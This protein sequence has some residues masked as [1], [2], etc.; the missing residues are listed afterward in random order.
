MLKRQ[1]LAV[2][3]I[4]LAAHVRWQVASERP[5]AASS[6]LSDASVAL[7]PRA[8]LLRQR[9][10]ADNF[11]ATALAETSERQ[12]ST[13]QEDLE[14]KLGAGAQTGREDP[15]ELTY[16]NYVH[17]GKEVAN[18]IDAIHNK[19]TN[20]L[21]MAAHKA[22]MKSSKYGAGLDGM[23][24][25][26][27]Q[28]QS[29]VNTY[30]RRIHRNFQN[31]TQSFDN[32]LDDGKVWEPTV[33]SKT[34]PEGLWREDLLK[35]LA[36]EPSMGNPSSYRHSSLK[37][38]DAGVELN[39][40]TT[41][42][43][44]HP[45]ASAVYKMGYSHGYKNSSFGKEH[46][47]SAGLPEDREP[48]A[49]SWS[50]AG[51]NWAARIFRGDSA[52][53]KP[54]ENG[55]LTRE[56]LKEIKDFQGPH[57]NLQTAVRKGYLLKEAADQ[58]MPYT[59]TMNGHLWATENAIFTGPAPSVHSWV[60]GKQMKQLEGFK[61]EFS[62]EGND[63]TARAENAATIGLFRKEKVDDTGHPALAKERDPERHKEEHGM[64]AGWDQHLKKQYRNLG[65]AVKKDTGLAKRGKDVEEESGDEDQDE[66]ED[67]GSGRDSE[68]RDEDASAEGEDEDEYDSNEVA[69]RGS[70]QVSGRAPV[71]H[72]MWAS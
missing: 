63:A 62:P 7:S 19:V 61:G 11:T 4:L 24:L 3:G 18:K 32:Q 33:F 25:A 30:K 58:L 9:Q 47:V 31:Q 38:H 35:A 15:L 52:E 26:I 34:L 8:V 5:N 40:A 57:I 39:A 36:E 48:Q 65:K 53:H 49:Y 14:H 21:D 22:E 42:E 17:Y 67:E 50:R 6:M 72:D 60:T 69:S 54:K 68:D 56:Q 16:P 37:A 55:W 43:F 64:P 13:K 70:A 66:D 2:G 23:R 27:R 46:G 20:D 12:Q 10:S 71:P 44:L 29:S 45:D 51:A 28:L 41:N 59:W 1:S